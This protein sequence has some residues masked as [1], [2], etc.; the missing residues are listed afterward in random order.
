LSDA[1][2]LQL[3]SKCDELIRAGRSNEVAPLISDLN[4]KRV[5]RPVCQRLAQVC[6]RAGL[7]RAGLRLLKAIVLDE[8]SSGATAGEVCEYAALLFKNGSLKE[9]LA[10]L[11]KIDETKAPEALLFRSFCSTSAWDYKNAIADLERFLILAEDPYQ[12]LVAKVNLV[13]AYIVLREFKKAEE[14]VGTILQVA[15]DRGHARLVGNCLEQRGS[16]YLLQSEFDR[17]HR[18][19]QDA[20]RIFGEGSNHDQLLVSKWLSLLS[21]LKSNSVEPLLDFRTTAVKYK[22]CESV[23]QCDLFRLKISFDQPTF[24]YLY[25]GSPMVNFRT[26]ML[27]DLPHAPGEYCFLG[28]NNRV[29]LDLKSGEVRG[30]SPAIRV[31]GKGL[32]LLNCLLDDFYVARNVGSLFSELYP[33]EYF[34]INSSP[35]RVQQV[36]LR[37]RQWLENQNLPIR[38]SHDNGTYSLSIT[39]ALT[40]AVPSERTAVDRRYLQLQNLQS[41]IGFGRRFTVTDACR[42]L[43]ISPSTFSRFST[44]ALASGKLMKF[45]QGKSTKYE[46][47][48]NVQAPRA[49]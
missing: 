44:W 7:V 46:L 8:K 2:Y 19:L 33:E 16:I 27:Q 20:Q 18:D 40:I 35:H 22:Q 47:V 15:R 26:L 42:K 32:K 39:G 25:A 10:R 11:Q 41:G 45:G 14:L 49:A 3:V 1:K 34:D 31:D 6:R 37:T 17:A 12:R 24:D 5:P 29:H 28:G 30:R 9:A 38:V 13:S 4:L 43:G 48:A 21:S 23:R 36:I